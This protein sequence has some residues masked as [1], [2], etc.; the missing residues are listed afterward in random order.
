MNEMS[1]TRMMPATL[2][3]LVAAATLAACSAGG[4]GGSVASIE[5]EWTLLTLNGQPLLPHSTINATFEDGQIGGFSGCNSYGGSY[6]LTGSRLNF[7]MVAMTLMA[8]LDEG[9]MEQEQAYTKALSNVAKFHLEGDRLELLDESGAALLVY[10]RQETFTGDPA[11]LINTEWQLL[12]LNGSP[13]DE[14]LPFTL[15]FAENRYSGLAGCRHVEGDYQAGDGDIQFPSLT[16][17]EMECPGADD[18]YWSKEGRFT[19]A[20]TWARRW[21]IVDDQLEIRTARGEALVFAPRPPMSAVALAGTAWSL[22]AF[23]EGGTTTSL[24]TD[25]EITLSFEAGQVVGS[26]GCNSY[27]GP[28]MLERDVLRISTITITEMYCTMPEG[29]MEQEARYTGILSDVT[30]WEWDA[31]QLTLHTADGRGLV[32]TATRQ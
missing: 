32:L 28:Y 7:G 2:L 14:T 11:A 1:K 16:M 10:A 9:V 19:D 20:L 22:T 29:V 30:L 21:R 23:I 18:A 12:T 5:G 24:L 13:L 17:V 3:F 25:T 6:T 15:A 31:D 27:G 4:V 8:C 26:A